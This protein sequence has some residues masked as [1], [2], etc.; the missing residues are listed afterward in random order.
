MFLEKHGI[1]FHHSKK[2]IQQQ[3][4]TQKTQNPSFLDLSQLKLAQPIISQNQLGFSGWSFTF[5]PEPRSFSLSK[6]SGQILLG[7]KY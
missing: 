3:K 7:Q 5:M 1:E 4:K 6:P 2:K